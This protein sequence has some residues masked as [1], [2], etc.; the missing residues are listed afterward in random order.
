MA[1]TARILKP[2]EHKLWDKFVLDNAAASVFH[3]TSWN[4]L[5]GKALQTE[6]YYVVCEKKGT[7]QA[8]MVGHYVQA[9]HKF[10]WPG[11]GYNG[12]LFNPSLNY[13]EPNNTYAA[14]QVHT[15]LIN[16]LSALADHV[17]IRNQPEVW[18]ARPYT[19]AKWRVETS[20]A[21]NLNCT[22]KEEVWQNIK[23]Q[24]RDAISARGL[25]LSTEI[26]PRERIRF[27]EEIRA[28][29]KLIDGVTE[30]GFGELVTIE[31]EKGKTQAIALVITSQPD[32]T[33]YLD[34]II[35]T[36]PKNEREALASL[37]WLCCKH[38]D[39]RY[40]RINLGDTIDM[41]LSR[42]HDDLGA[43]LTPFHIATFRKARK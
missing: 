18:N 9:G 22:N 16:R 34:K 33:L 27:C 10:I 25:S 7:I 2:D 5:I 23:P 30:Q 1:L 28:P 39:G 8:G 38:Y 26:E 40:K 41:D 17:S 24:L 31:N 12:P 29:L 15:E 20:Y 11:I 36:V 14:Y 4:A 21:H 3:T 13:P 35:Y 42:T 19:F 6:C 32:N 43:I 37:V